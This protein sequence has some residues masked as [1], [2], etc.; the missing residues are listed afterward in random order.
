M[1]E[2]MS[3]MLAV[4]LTS[5][6]CVILSACGGGGAGDDAVS[7]RQDADESGTKRILA[8][9]PGVS[10][11]RNGL[12]RY[13]STNSFPT[14]STRSTNYWVDVVFSS[15]LPRVD[16]ATI[17]PSS[18][19]P[20]F[21]SNRWDT[22]SVNLGVSFRSDISGYVTGVRFYKGS[23]NTGVHIGTLWSSTGEQLASATF[24]NESAT[25]WQQVNFA[26]PVAIAANTVYV[27]SYLAPNGGYA[28]DRYYFATEETDR[29]PLH[30]LQDGVTY[31]PP[32]PPPEE[33]PVTVVPL[34]D[35]STSLEPATVIDTGTAIVTRFAD[36]ARDRHARESNFRSYDH[37]LSWYWE[38]RTATIE[39]IDKVAKG[40][41]EVI[42]NVYPLTRLS[43]PEF[44]AFFRGVTTPGE[45]SSN[46]SMSRV[47]TGT[48]PYHYTTTLTTYT[49]QIPSRP[50]RIGDRMELEISQFL[51]GQL[52]G[53]SNYY[54][55]A[56]LY[57]VGQG[58]LVPWEGLGPQLDSFALPEL[59][60][61]AGRATLPYQYSNE[62][63]ER[64]KQI[65][66]QMAPA[67]AQAFMLGRRLHHTNFDTGAHSE[68]PGENPIYAEQVGKLG[69]QFYAASCVD[70]HI[71]NGRAFPPEPGT[72][73][74][75]AVTKIG[76]ATGAPDADL[77]SSLQPLR[78]TGAG[79]GSVSIGN[80]VLI[81][82]A[83]GDGTPY[84]LRRPAYDFVGKTPTHF[85]V[86]NTPPLVGL[87][88]LEA[89][90]ES[91]I[92]A[93]ADP[94]DGN[95]D[96]VS[97]RMQTVVD[98]ETGQTR[99]GRFGWK[100][101][102]ARISHQI[103]SALNADMG[104]TTSIFPRSDCGTSQTGCGSAGVKL[105]NLDLANMVRYVSLLGVAARRNLNDA[106]ALQGEALFSSAGCA[107][108]HA[109]TLTTSAQHPFAELRSQTIRPYT[110]L[111]LHDMGD[112]L[113]DTLPEANAS[114]AEWRTA[115]LWSLGLTAGVSGG[116]E[117]YLHDGRARDLSE[118]ILWHGGEAEGAKEAFRN[119]NATSRAAVLRFIQSL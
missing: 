94:A 74:T 62:P 19:V 28:A 10:V 24:T 53:R 29:S 16:A 70:C 113:A 118:A 72:S 41:T 96:G 108:C 119:M 86:R 39:I 56:V 55:T 50:I 33:P 101:G 110:D 115:P 112:G 47:G 109:P 8:A 88:L 66:G 46:I 71:N 107:A 32:P 45:Y 7:A 61:T 95:G 1:H 58:G 22:S 76:T 20:V 3:R 21:A 9:V 98:P 31:I 65:P 49:K 23:A 87:G 59:A 34:Y 26:S 37:Y 30:A 92:A 73:I 52:H 2:R 100:A 103:A 27:A 106:Q 67:S 64:F 84:Q 12:Y 43:A 6:A 79:E 82:G 13:A 40:G 105:N 14:S 4:A 83:Y 69:P 81:S 38:Q 36:R 78:T 77:G 42:F 17:W 89:V 91:A 102:T 68:L 85:S 57:I 75:N 25:G 117:A 48:N 18:A 90:P 99:L 5:M 63:L 104:V 60:W 111:L 80:Y 35:A 15:T 114:G 93:L 54:G 11:T 116:K 44:R 97:G 51:T